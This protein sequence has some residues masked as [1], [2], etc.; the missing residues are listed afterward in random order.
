MATLPA[1]MENQAQQMQQSNNLAT[2]FAGLSLV[3]QIGLLVGLAASIALGFA[4]VLWS[5]Q[6]DYSPLLSDLSGVDATQAV[7]VLRANDIPYKIDTNQGGLLVASEHLHRARMQLAAIGIADNPS[8]GFELLDKEQGLGT[9]QFMENISY[10]RGLEG[11][12]ARTIA[13]LKSVR[14]AR[15]HLAMPKSSV[16][17]RDERKPSASVFVE[18]ASG[19]QLQEEQVA[20]IVNLV[21]SSVPQ[22]SSSEVTIVD[23]N[24]RLLS[25]QGQTA[26]TALAAHQFEYTRKYEQV[27]VKRVHQILEPVLGRDKFKAEVSADLDFTAV[28][29][30]EEIYNPQ[31]SSVRSEQTL[32]ERKN[33]AAAVAGG[34]PGALS[35]Q[36]PAAGTTDAAAVAAEQ[37]ATGPSGT[38]RRQATRN[39]EL[40]RTI[41]YTKRPQGSINRL[42][43][44]VVVD[45]RPSQDGTQ[46]PWPQE[47][48]DRLTELVRGAV[49]YDDQRGDRVTVVNAAFAPVEI[50]EP[51][52]AEIP[53]WEQPWFQQW[54]KRAVAGILLLILIFA[55]IRPIMKSL[56]ND[57]AKQKQLALAVANAQAAQGG[58]P[59]P[60]MMA[61][62]GAGNN[63][64]ALLPGPGRSYDMQ[65]SA[66]QGLIADN[67]Q[68]AA[69]VLKQWVGEHE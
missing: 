23:Q 25:D 33:G 55:V 21:A 50:V 64:T 8:V 20:A 35:N 2:G 57:G 46:A 16:F 7:D 12:L 37:T 17:V 42:S 27:L 54:S 56:S 43:V 68:R 66:A 51:E 36:P 28:E 47:E 9:S 45:N 44:A 31:T 60:G 63:R 1:E 26:A 67:P 24:G 65:L 52:V 59:P 61:Q 13:S 34:V 40:D 3:R 6:P 29:Q 49:G 18:L 10:R 19:R 22:L 14:S 5:Q 48:L 39:Y 32:D 4:V 62:A 11:E 41:S 38:S 53:I 15:V 69:Q 58:N 30:T